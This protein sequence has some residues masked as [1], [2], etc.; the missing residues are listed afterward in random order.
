MILAKNTEAVETIH[1]SP[2]LGSPSSQKMKGAKRRIIDLATDVDSDEHTQMTS[3][4]Q[5]PCPPSSPPVNP[6]KRPSSS[7]Y[8]HR[9]NQ[10]TAGPSSYKRRNIEVSTASSS[11]VDPASTAYP[12]LPHV[13]SDLRRAVGGQM[14][15]NRLRDKQIKGITEQIAQASKLLQKALVALNSMGIDH[16]LE[17]LFI[18][19][20]GQSLP[21]RIETIPSRKGK[22]KQVRV[23]YLFISDSITN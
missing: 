20:S 23:T 10:S 15:D 19:M 12:M 6:K 8:L 17:K 14:L 2:L 7:Q 9:Q 5:A 4:S 11:H 21:S 13:P 22:E 1:A 16:E 3:D 18:G